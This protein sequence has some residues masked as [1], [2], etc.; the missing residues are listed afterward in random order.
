[1]VVHHGDQLSRQDSPGSLVVESTRLL[2]NLATQLPISKYALGFGLRRLQEVLL[3]RWML[4]QYGL[5]P[6][7]IELALF[8]RHAVV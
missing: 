2:S 5:E 3:L 7:Q 8:T 4:L 6:L 1:M